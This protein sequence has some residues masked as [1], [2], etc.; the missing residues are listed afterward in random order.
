MLAPSP[1]QQPR[2]LVAG[3][4]PAAIKRAAAV[5]TGWYPYNLTIS[6]AKDP[7][8]VLSMDATARTYRYLDQSELDQIRQANAKAGKRK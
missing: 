3:H 1:S 5:G 4:S 8:G 7:S 2:M 6:G